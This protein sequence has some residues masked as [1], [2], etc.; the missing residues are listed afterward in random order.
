MS[1]LDAI[2]A[3]HTKDYSPPK[4]DRV[5]PYWGFY[6]RRQ[7]KM[8]MPTL[9]KDVKSRPGFYKNPLNDFKHKLNQ[10]ARLWADYNDYE[11]S[12][13]LRTSFGKLWQKLFDSEG[14][15]RF[16]CEAIDT[17]HKNLLAWNLEWQGPGQAPFTETDDGTLIKAFP[18]IVVL[19][20]DDT[21]EN[22][23]GRNEHYREATKL[24]KDDAFMVNHPFI[25]C[26]VNI[27]SAYFGQDRVHSIV[28]PILDTMRIALDLE[29]YDLPV[30]KTQY[31]F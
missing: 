22:I 10:S 16:T 12:D 21:I 9:R 7:R 31:Q 19:L 8:T 27:D 5:V 14:N 29:I 23:D 15:L 4:K 2:I 3:M 26:A 30:E 1:R 6:P 11:W 24:V 18:S 25:L 20:L 28:S 17:E 13:R